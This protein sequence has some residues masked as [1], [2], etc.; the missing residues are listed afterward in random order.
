MTDLAQSKA[1]AVS[2]SY[3]A[4]T[5]FEKNLSGKELP[6]DFD[7]ARFT[8]N[9]MALMQKVNQIQNCSPQS[10]AGALL[11][12]A[13]YN[14]DPNPDLGLAYYIP[15]KD[16]N[17][18][19]QLEFKIGYRGLLERA[20]RNG[21]ISKVDADIVYSND[22]FEVT[23][24]DETRFTHKPNFVNR[25]EPVLAYAFAKYRGELILRVMNRQEIEEVKAMSDS[26]NSN[27]SPWN[28]RP[29]EMWKK[30]V[31]RNL[32][33]LLPLEI[34]KGVTQY[35]DA[36]VPVTAIKQI[37][38]DGAVT[39]DISQVDSYALP[40]PELIEEFEV[41]DEPAP[42]PQPKPN[43]QPAL[44]NKPKPA[45]LQQKKPEVTQ[46][47]ALTNDTLEKILSGEIAWKPK[48]YGNAIYLNNAKIT[49]SKDQ[50]AK[51]R[52]L[53]D[54]NGKPAPQ[55]QQDAPPEEDLPF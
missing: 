38:K 33:K 16:R 34:T 5:L 25:G 10:V 39:A 47:G 37:E 13:A 20:Y 42:V 24:T 7:K 6:K 14:L 52:S 29:L 23:K 28:T 27:F 15:R 43:P 4:L 48:I 26:K 49:I 11:L 31:L 21:N 45:P 3:P 17:G 36:I 32:F 53:I 35:D 9:A 51:L 50:E 8:I 18:N 41:I 22:T 19:L 46:G 55:A 40:E 12:T 1:V 54:G 44:E 30:T 2:Q